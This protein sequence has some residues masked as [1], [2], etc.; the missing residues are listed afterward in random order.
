M[1]P[2]GALCLLTPAMLGLTACAPVPVDQAERSCLTAA[3]DASG[4]RTEAG[5]GVGSDGFRG[6][7]F[8]V[9]VSSDYMAGR[10]P[11]EVFEDCVLR[12]SG[13]PPS[14]PLYEQPGWRAS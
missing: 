10:D 5:F 12:R 11:S 6:G 3:R 2:R 8:S 13:Q 1:R 4:P 14:R 9:G 7:Y